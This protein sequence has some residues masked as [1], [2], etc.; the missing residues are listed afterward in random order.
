MSAARRDD[1]TVCRLLPVVIVG[2]LL[3]LFG[4]GGGGDQATP[5]DEQLGFDQ[6]GILKRQARAETLIRDCMRAQGFEYVPV[7]PGAQ[8]AALV[9]SAG[10]SEEDFE[11]QLGYGITT[12]YDKER[13]LPANPNAVIYNALTPADQRA[14]D[15]TL[16]GENHGATFAQAV[17]TGFFGQLGGC[18]K[19]ATE[20]VFGGKELLNT[21]VSLLD[22]LDQRV[23]TDRRVVAAIDKWSDCMRDAGYD[24]LGSPEQVDVLLARKLDLIVGPPDA[25]RDTYDAAALAALQRD[26]VAMVRSDIECEKKHVSKVQDAVQAEYEKTFR[27]EHVDLIKGVPPA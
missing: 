19:S 7:D 1:R 6:E 16:Y 27:E 2:M 11:K 5:V 4:C 10:L 3:L 14:Y 12:L 20:E 22:E 23:V 8:R 24:S 25:R 15:D 18:T 13:S 26:E 9:G 21:L 17:D